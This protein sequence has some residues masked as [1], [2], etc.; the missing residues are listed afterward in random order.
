[1]GAGS[2]RCRG[3][4]PQPSGRAPMQQPEQGPVTQWRVAAL[5]Q[6]LDQLPGAPRTGLYPRAWTG[7][8]GGAACVHALDLRNGGEGEGKTLRGDDANSP[9]PQTRQ[10]L[11]TEGALMPD[12]PDVAVSSERVSGPI[13]VAGR[14]DELVVRLLQPHHSREPAP[15]R[16][17]VRGPMVDGPP[18]VSGRPMQFLLKDVALAGVAPPARYAAGVFPLL[19]AA[20]GRPA[21][22]AP[23][24]TPPVSTA[25]HALSQAGLILRAPRPD[26]LVWR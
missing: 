25:P 8:Q 2:R 15:H 23:R 24:A 3:R 16:G 11:T 19:A 13:S 1:M 14:S 22:T 10:F 18:V 21:V 26:A 17:A 9:R 5:P 6:D 12:V 7:F 20:A 4:G